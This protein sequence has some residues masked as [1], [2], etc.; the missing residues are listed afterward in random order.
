MPLEGEYEPSPEAWVRDQVAR[1]EA[2][3]GREANTLR[4]TGLPVVI[5]TTR[6]RKSGKLR[7][8]ALMKVEHDGKY[9]LVA[10][11]GGAPEHPVWYHNLTADPDALM[12][13]DGAERWD[14][15]AREL[16]GEERQEW[17]DRAVAA[18]PSYAEYQTRT[19]R[20]IPVLLAERR[21]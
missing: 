13:Q 19:D 7:K 17:W 12:V 18:Y 9:A 2:T 16:S 10:S 4:G 8:M 5:F 14:A 11:K 1:Y 6:G 3:D 20:L 21:D 15:H